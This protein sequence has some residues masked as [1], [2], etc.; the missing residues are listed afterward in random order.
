M[1]MNCPRRR[2]I[3]HITPIAPTTSKKT[4]NVANVIVIAFFA[5]SFV[6]KEVVVVV[7]VVIV[8]VAAPVSFS[9]AG[10]LVAGV[11]SQK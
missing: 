2:R 4:P 8:V 5:P 6:A 11:V 7:V 9:R 1:E 10:A 3:K